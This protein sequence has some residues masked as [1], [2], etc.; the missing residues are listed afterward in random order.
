[1]ALNNGRKNDENASSN[2]EA[3]ILYG[4]NKVRCF[5]CGELLEIGTKIC[6]YC[7]TEQENEHFTLSSK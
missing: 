7:K 6:P 1:M 3:K 5:A 2:K 4:E